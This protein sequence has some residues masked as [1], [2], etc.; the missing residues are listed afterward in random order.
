ETKREFPLNYRN[1][2]SV[3]VTPEAPDPGLFEPVAV[4]I[5][6]V[7]PSFEDETDDTAYYDGQGFGNETVTGVR[8]SL[9]FSGHRHYGDPAQD[10][11]ASLAFEVGAKRETQLKWEQPNGNMITGNVTISG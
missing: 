8:A 4:G 1:K 7:D 10:F 9:V 11:I 6:N 3:N 5:S 2:Y